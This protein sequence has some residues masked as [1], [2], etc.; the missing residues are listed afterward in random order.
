ML[1]RGL[2]KV[3]QQWKG[4]RLSVDPQQIFKKPST[5]A[6]TGPA[7]TSTESRAKAFP[8]QK[9][10]PMPDIDYIQFI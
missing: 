10:K 8:S 6:D 9:K 3:E 1:D 4:I 7:K 2:Q 5:R